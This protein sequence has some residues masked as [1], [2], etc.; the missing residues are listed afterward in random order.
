[1]RRTSSGRQPPGRCT[2]QLLEVG[3]RGALVISELNNNNNNNNNNNDC[4]T[5]KMMALR[6][7][8]VGKFVPIDTT[9]RYKIFVF[10]AP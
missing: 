6:S 8:T 3:S 1:M 2:E 5:L 7:S 9:S 10:S 4:W